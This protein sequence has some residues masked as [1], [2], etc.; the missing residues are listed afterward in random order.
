M[1]QRTLYY[2]M[3]LDKDTHAACSENNGTFTVERVFRARVD[4]SP[5]MIQ[6]ALRDHCKSK[7]I[8]VVFRPALPMEALDFSDTA[9]EDAE[10]LRPRA[11]SKEPGPTDTTGKRGG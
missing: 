6:A 4:D 11:K 1:A 10:R 7:E 8:D 9:R 3:A 5:D 2:V